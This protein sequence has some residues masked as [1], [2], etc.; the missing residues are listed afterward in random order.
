MSP[1]EEI[2]RYKYIVKNDKFYT[3]FAKEVSKKGY[4]KNLDRAQTKKIIYAVLFSD[5][6]KNKKITKEYKAIFKSIFPTVFEILSL[7]KKDKHNT[8][9]I[10]LQSIE[11]K[12][13]LENAYVKIMNVLPNAPLFSIHDSLI[14]TENYVASV[15]AILEEELTNATGYSPHLKIE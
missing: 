15:K 12:I 8:L 10:L 2:E 3:E 9:A 11:S 13:V 5:N 1:Y 14:T 4:N 7:I 6:T